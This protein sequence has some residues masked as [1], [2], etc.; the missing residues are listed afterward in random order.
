MLLATGKF[1]FIKYHAEAKGEDK[2]FLNKSF[3]TVE[4]IGNTWHYM[5]IH[6]YTWLYMVIHGN[7]WL[8][9]AIH[10]NTWQYMVIH[11]YTWLYMV[12]HGNTW[13]LHGYTW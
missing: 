9:I 8:Y 1:S 6:G 3:I 7:T 10:G 11:G 12:I 5:A 4:H 13:L 2:K